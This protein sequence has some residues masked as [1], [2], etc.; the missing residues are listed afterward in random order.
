MGET[1]QA[2]SVQ[3]LREFLLRMGDN[4][5]ILGHRISEWCGH[6]PVLEED[7]AMANVAL[8]LIGQTQYWLGMAAEKGGDGKTADDLAYLRDAYE[9]RN[10][11]L[12]EQ[13]NRDYACT[14]MRQFL[15]D[16]WHLLQLEALTASSDLDVAE[17]A[18]KAIKEV[19]YHLERSTDLVIRLGD[20]SEESHA[21]MQKALDDLW[22]YVG[23]MFIDD[24]VDV[25]LAE[26]GV[27]PRPSSL[28][29]P[30]FVQVRAVLD[31]ATLKMP[32]DDFAHR[33]GKQGRHTEHLGYILAEM[34]FLQRAYP[35]ST[36]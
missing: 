16:S 26:A 7:I 12:V 15:F 10:L 24:A 28:R 17:V 1:V 4:T 11:L 2:V 21:R 35:G 31:E 5:L 22:S 27:A 23:E 25:E 14:L 36:W 8:D 9:F 20:G 29:D 30:W 19:S 6:S 18:Q 34:Q 33:G 3:T 13:P 32:E